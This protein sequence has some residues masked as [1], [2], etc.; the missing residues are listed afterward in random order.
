MAGDYLEDETMNFTAKIGDGSVKTFKASG[1]G[2]SGDPHIPE[3]LE[4]N[5]TAIK[6]ALEAIKAEV[7]GTLTALATAVGNVAHDSADS[8]NPVKVGGRA[9]TSDITAVANNDRTDFITDKSGKQINL[10]YAIP[11]NFVSGANSADLTNTNSTQIIAA[12]GSGL[13]T[14]VTDILV[15][16]SH[17]ST[18]TVVKILSGSTLLARGYA[19]PGGGGFAKNFAIPLVGGAN[20]AINAQC[21]TS[22]AAVQVTIS[23]YKGA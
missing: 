4:S 20:T 14:Y 21:E 17:S 3:H 19:A 10:P 11:E 23:G 6:S 16:N 13:K 5:S 18:G 9:R 8:G 1:A 2:S 15:T 12:Q 22:G 7:E